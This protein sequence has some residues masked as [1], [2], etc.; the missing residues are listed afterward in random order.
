MVRLGRLIEQLLVPRS[1]GK[2]HRVIAVSHATAEEIITFY[3]QVEKKIVVIPEAT[4]LQDI[5][6][7]SDELPTQPYMLFVGTMEPRKNLNAVLDAY[8]LLLEAGTTTHRFVIAGNLGWKNED[9]HQ[10]LEREPF[11]T[12]V[13]LLGKVSDARLVALYQGADFVVA[14]SLY[15]GFGLVVLEAMGFGKPVITANLSSLPEVAGNAA[16]LVDPTNVPDIEIAMRTLIKD[17]DLHE[18]LSRDSV[19]RAKDFSW[20]RAAENTLK[21]LLD[22]AEGS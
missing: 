13:D 19:E 9:I 3:P 4:S 11:T 10:K 1:L 22:V 8:R 5:A 7:E 21:V 12:C 16:L 18:R 17:R 15:E 6:A 2:A 14:P 20:D